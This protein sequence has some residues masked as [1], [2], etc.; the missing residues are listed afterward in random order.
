MKKPHNRNYQRIDNAIVNAYKELLKE[1]GNP[2]FSITELCQK[3]KV[4]R[5]T[6]YKHYSGLYQIT[7]YLEDE[8][9]YRLFDI[10]D[11]NGEK[12]EDF[13]NNPKPAL[14]RLNHNLITN[15]DYYKRV[16]RPERI[17]YI[18]DKVTNILFNEFKKQ[19][20]KVNKRPD[21]ILKAKIN[22]TNFVG[23]ITNLYIQWFNGYLDCDISN[24][25]D[26]LCTVLTHVHRD[27]KSL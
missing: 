12:I 15:L 16:F 8:L 1:K 14:E 4:N 11:T 9:I 17:R 13:L 25:S 6:F 18:I 24:I 19:Y 7:D 26:Y 21:V 27:R 3:A 22:I 23:S 5:T 2:D 20:P 10:N